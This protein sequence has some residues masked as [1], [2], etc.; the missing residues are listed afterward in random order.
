MGRH[1]NFAP[2]SAARWL[3]CPYSAIIGATLPNVDS[4]ASRE[5]TR[6]HALIETAIF[7]APIPDEESDD[8]AYGV[9]LVLDFI[10]Q[11]GGPTSVL[12]ER[13]VRL[14]DDVWGTADIMQPK[15][16]ITTL[17]DY[18]NGAMDILVDQNMQLMTY[19]V[20]ILEEFGPSKFYR[21]VIIQPNS[22]TAGDQPD[23]KQTI[24]P[25]EAVEFHRELVLD[26]VDRGLGG[27][28][29]IPGRHCRYCSAFGNCPATQ[30]MLPMI[31]T[32]VKFM[33]TEVP[34]ETAVRLLRVLRG[35]DDFRKNL[36]KD[37]MRRFAA[38]QKVPD[39]S[40]GITSTHRKWQDDRLAVSRLMTAF[41]LSGVDPVTP[42]T[43]EKMGAQG[44]EI[45]SQL[46]FKPPGNAK[47]VY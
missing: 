23:V 2:S 9:E 19:D 15:P 40:V 36:E 45:V 46:A 33:P 31:M 32:S 24:V 27:E 39:A 34:S 41:G 14:N 16:D 7:G 17:V 25:L 38:G 47:L 37:L 44:K 11:L 6:I 43:A 29:P 8:V 26:A 5:G 21:N 35:L 22:R 3:N 28:G 1:A 4:D 42:A 30:E 18:K 13:Q 10:R 12:V 20:A